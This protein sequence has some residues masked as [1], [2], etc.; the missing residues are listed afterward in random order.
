MA[1][2]LQAGGTLGDP[3]RRF[4]TRDA[5][6]GGTELVCLECQAATPNAAA[7]LAHTCA[8]PQRPAPR[9]R[10]ERAADTPT[11]E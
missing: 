1:T 4:A 6:T 8:E 11:E 2:T 9:P 3:P 7:F 5:E 10:R